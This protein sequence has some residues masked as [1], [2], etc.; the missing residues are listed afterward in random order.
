MSR[1]GDHWRQA[2]E[3]EL[4][5]VEL[6]EL[7]PIREPL[8][9]AASLFPIRSIASALSRVSLAFGSAAEA[10]DTLG[11]DGAT[12]QLELRNR[13]WELGAACV[14]ARACLSALGSE[15]EPLRSA[16]SAAALLQEMKKEAS[17]GE[18][19]ACRVEVGPPLIAHIGG[20]VG[21][22]SVGATLMR[23]AALTRQE[24]DATEGPTSRRC[25]ETGV[26]LARGSLVGLGGHAIDAAIRIAESAARSD[27]ELFR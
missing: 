17:G 16:E 9:A 2:L 13:L 7:E 4:W 8:L 18:L 5:G 24:R 10:A 23:E 26:R 3:V 6:G 21:P 27:D 20:F 19:V 22:L 15:E 14:A 25:F 12:C 1:E 11:E